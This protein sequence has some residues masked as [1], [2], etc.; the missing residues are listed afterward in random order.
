MMWQ[1]SQGCD[2]HGSIP[3]GSISSHL[4]S[5]LSLPLCGRGAPA[6]ARLAAPLPLGR[7]RTRLGDTARTGGYRRPRRY[8]PCISLVYGG[9]DEVEDEDEEGTTSKM[10]EAQMPVDS[11][12]GDLDRCSVLGVRCSV[13]NGRPDVCIHMHRSGVCTAYVYVCVYVSRLSH[14]KHTQEFGYAR[15]TMELVLMSGG[16][17][18]RMER[19]NAGASFG[20]EAPPAGPRWHLASAP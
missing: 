5:G 12:R 6:A 1:H 13:W 15:Y 19:Q 17:G 9:E 7:T 8:S 3:A 10:D 16:R 11:L 14:Q 2:I 18:V 20:R 4:L